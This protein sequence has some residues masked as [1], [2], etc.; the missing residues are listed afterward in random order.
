M[1]IPARLLR[2]LSLWAPLRDADVPEGRVEALSRVG[3]GLYYLLLLPLGA[4]GAVMLRRRGQGGTLLVLSAPLILMLATTAVTLGQAR[5]RHVGEVALVV[6]AS[7]AA[8]QLNRR[9]E[10]ARAP[11]RASA[12]CA[13]WSEATRG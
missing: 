2:T 13:R 8:V 6:L 7:F 1:V 10:S 11:R 3:Q 4:A 9:R 5:F 12:P